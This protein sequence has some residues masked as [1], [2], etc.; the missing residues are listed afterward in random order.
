MSKETTYT[1]AGATFD[2]PARRYRYRL[3]RRWA[4]GRTLLWIMLNP[5]TA[6]ETVLDPTLRRCDD[7]ARR[8]GYGSFEV[9][10]L[11]AWRA[12]DPMELARVTKSGRHNIIGEQQ[13]ATN[14]VAI[15]AAVTD[16][17][18]IVCGWGRA[19]IAQV[20]GRNVERMLQH[21]Q[22]GCLGTNQDGSPMH[23]LYI[24][25]DTALQVYREAQ[26]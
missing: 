18:S 1:A 13:G 19:P 23:P 9:V 4:H 25:G 24:K 14:D 20:R 17:T 21:R 7:F 10:N 22:L 5:S 15:R 16:A 11:F 8:W 3:W 26:V 6:D 2:E 12:T